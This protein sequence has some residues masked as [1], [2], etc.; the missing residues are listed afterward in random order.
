MRIAAIARQGLFNTPQVAEP[1]V[2]WH[3]RG[4][5]QKRIMFIQL[6]Y[7]SRTAETLVPDH[8]K[9]ILAASPRNNTRMGVTGASWLG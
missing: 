4:F 7:A 8:L 1:P 5:T 9:S 3:T 6:T 2:D